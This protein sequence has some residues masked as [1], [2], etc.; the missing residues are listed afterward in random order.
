MIQF[1]T[2]R[3]ET[4]LADTAV[5]VNPK[6]ERY[7]DLIGK[8]VT[9]P[10][11]NREIKIIADDYVDKEYGTGVVKITPGHDHNDFAVGERHKLEQI[12]ILNDNGTLNELTGVY[13]GMDVKTTR[14]K[15]LKDLENI[16]LLVKCEKLNHSVGTHDRCKAVVEPRLKTQ[17]FVRMKELAEPA[18]NAFKTGDLK[19]HPERFGKIYSHWLSNIR[20]WCISRQLWWGHRIP[21][22]FC[23]CG[24]IIVARET[25]DICF[26]CN[27]NDL[28]QEEDI[29]DTWFSS[30]LWPFSTLGWPEKTPELDY[31]YPT[32]TMVMGWEI[33]FFWGVR[34]VFSGMEM[35]GELPFKDLLF[36]GMVCDANGDKMAKS[37]GNGINPLDMIEKYG[38][39]ALRLSLISGNTLGSDFRFREE[40]I[41]TCRNFTNKIWNAARFLIMQDTKPVGTTAPVVYNLNLQDS[42]KWLISACN[43][44]IREVTAALE[45]FDIGM[46]A[47]KVQEFIWD[48]FCDWAIEMAKPRLLA[49]DGAAAATLRKVFINAL[50]LLHPF[51]PFI[52]EEV[53]GFVQEDEETIMLSEWPVY[54]DEDNFEKEEQTIDCIKDAVKAVRSIRVEKDVPPSK[55]ITMV[56][57]TKDERQEKIYTQGISY[58]KTLSSADEIYINRE[59][60]ENAVSVVISGA[61]IYIPLADLVDKDKEITRLNRETERLSAEITRCEA[62]LANKGFTDKAKPELVAAEEKKLAEYRDMFTKVQ[63]E[64]KGLLK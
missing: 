9:V 39:D 5:A 7:A 12:N 46:A 37:K 49:G 47:S 19:I 45:V 42:D 1:A 58:L 3:P 20:D 29:L 28:K 57:N 59:I 15:I 2:T 62:K 4:I 14:E 51:M 10:F 22:W 21:A 50:K 26:K 43:K 18:L 32:T 48:E 35:M 60:P 25:P 34:M 16:G 17:W 11:V 38:T 55:K 31:F 44:L 54:N 63:G 53:F 36:H 13:V 41:T 64:L 24:E 40:K 27:S 52:T 56:I 23:G 61:V 30:A 6:D 33:L 8:T